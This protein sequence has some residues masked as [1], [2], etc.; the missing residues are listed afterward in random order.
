MNIIMNIVN[1]FIQSEGQQ[2]TSVCCQW[3]GSASYD[4]YVHVETFVLRRKFSGKITTEQ[5]PP[6]V[7]HKAKCNKKNF[8]NH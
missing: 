6:N 5:Q 7:M 1:Q 8:I 2:L 4:R 3:R